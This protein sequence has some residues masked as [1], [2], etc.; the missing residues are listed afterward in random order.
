MG[1]LVVI[2]VGLGSMFILLAA[3]GVLK[4]PDFYMRMSVSTKAVTLGV[5]LILVA[6]AFSFNDFSI[7]TRVLA[8]IV[9]LLLTAPVAAHMIGRSGYF[10]RVK[11]W[12]K[13]VRDD[14]EGKYD[15][16]SHEL[17]SEDQENNKER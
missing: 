2:L 15:R 5:G 1:V 16:E 13:S 3:V 17:L 12:D 11:M 7:T 14:L 8:I 4:M 6:A 10:V 9:F